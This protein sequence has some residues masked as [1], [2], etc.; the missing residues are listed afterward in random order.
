MDTMTK[1]FNYFDLKVE[2]APAIHGSTL[3]NYWELLSQ[4]NKRFPT[5]NYLA[6]AVSHV[7]IY[8]N[9]LARNQKSI[10]VLEDDV[11]IHRN[12]HA[13]TAEFMNTLPHNWDL[14]YFA[15][16]PLSADQ[17]MW[18]YVEIDHLSLGPNLAH[19]RN[20]WSMMGYAMSDRL[21]KHMVDVYSATYPME[22]DRY[23]VDVVQPGTEF[24]SYCIRPQIVAGEDGYSDNA[25][26][27]WTGLP[28]K[29]IDSRHAAFHD[30]V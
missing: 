4:T 3:K 23:L 25:G 20:L 7:Q 6:C 11:R 10:L 21:M 15:Y 30:Y 2:R 17:S 28:T 5:P 9:A 27:V 8:S 19:A 13:M 14:L 1:R 22:I 16:I 18:T 26:I 24:Q 12:S 29:S